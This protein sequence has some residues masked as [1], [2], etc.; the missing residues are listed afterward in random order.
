[1]KANTKIEISNVWVE[2]RDVRS[3]VHWPPSQCEIPGRHSPTSHKS[4]C[5]CN[6]KRWFLPTRWLPVEHTLVNVLAI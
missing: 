4:D 3:M 6:S 2:I 5:I 1:M